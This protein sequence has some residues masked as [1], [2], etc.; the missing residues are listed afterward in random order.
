[1]NVDKMLLSDQIFQTENFEYGLLLKH[2]TLNALTNCWATNVDQNPEFL[3]NCLQETSK[4]FEENWNKFDENEDSNKL[5][6][7]KRLKH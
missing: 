5:V 4:K 3:L 2:D 1:M 6:R 7:I